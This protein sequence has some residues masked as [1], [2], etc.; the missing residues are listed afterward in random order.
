MFNGY[1]LFYFEVIFKS[2]KGYIQIGPTKTAAL[3][4]ST[5][6]MRVL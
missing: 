5:I 2:D 1:D 3:L 6:E 4:I